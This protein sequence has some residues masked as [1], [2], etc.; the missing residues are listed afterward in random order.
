MV[1]GREFGGVHVW[2]LGIKEWRA[3]GMKESGPTQSW[4]NQRLQMPG[5]V[6][7][8]AA[9]PGGG[10]VLRSPIIPGRTA[11][12]WSKKPTPMGEGDDDPMTAWHRLGR[13]YRRPMPMPTVGGQRQQMP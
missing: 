2:A 8:M 7:L 10:L 13:S 5:T 1:E 11:A 9:L 3:E 4:S 6:A 12:M